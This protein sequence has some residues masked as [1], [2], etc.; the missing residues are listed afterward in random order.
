MEELVEIDKSE[1][2]S[3]KLVYEVNNG[4]VYKNLEGRKQEDASLL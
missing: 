1:S 3:A 4:P 2:F